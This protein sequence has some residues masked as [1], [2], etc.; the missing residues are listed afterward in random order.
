[1]CDFNMANNCLICDCFLKSAKEW[2]NLGSSEI[3]KNF[4]LTEF[5]C[6]P[7]PLGTCHVCKPCYRPCH[8][9]KPCYRKLENATSSVK[10]MQELVSRLV[11]FST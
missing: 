5:V 3:G 1:M 2:R 4:L 10:T 11:L 8:V 7:D 6:V 9:C